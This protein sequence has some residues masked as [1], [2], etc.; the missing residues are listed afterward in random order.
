MLQSCLWA[1]GRHLHNTGSVLGPCKP[2]KV[3]KD[4]ENADTCKV[5]REG[6]KKLFYFKLHAAFI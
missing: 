4:S 3:R 2:D 5:I 6:E 1:G